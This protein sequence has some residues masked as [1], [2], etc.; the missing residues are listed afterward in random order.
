MLSL[1]DISLVNV[2]GRNNI[3]N[4]KSQIASKFTPMTDSSFDKD[5]YSTGHS[6][7]ALEE[8]QGLEANPVY[9][10][11]HTSGKYTLK[12]GSPGQ[13][14]AMVLPNFSDK[15]SGSAPDMG[16]QENGAPPMRF[17]RRTL[18]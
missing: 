14:A 3:I 8:K 7:W 5:L 18:Q 2:I 17:G 1:D 13:D 9:D 16:A 4:A 15:F 6:N 10:S 11:T 12:Q